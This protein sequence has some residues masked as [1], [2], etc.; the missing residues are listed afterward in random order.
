MEPDSTVNLDKQEAETQAQHHE[1]AALSQVSAALSGL[2]DLDAILRV[3]LDNMLNTM[4][5]TIG[6]ILLVDEQ[7]QTLSYRV[8]QGLSNEYV[9]ENLTA[10]DMEDDVYAE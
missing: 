8:H 4:D 7:T 1:L 6:G 2:W 3:A 5:E 9:D 10:K